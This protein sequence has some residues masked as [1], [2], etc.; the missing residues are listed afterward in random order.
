MSIIHD[1]LKKVEG[2]VTVLDGN[3]SNA[4]GFP[5]AAGLRA[6]RGDTLA[7]TQ[8]EN[9]PRGVSPRSL[10][11]VLLLGVLL[12]SSASWVFL[13]KRSLSNADHYPPVIQEGVWPPLGVIPPLMAVKTPVAAIADNPL[14][15]GI[16][17]YRAGKLDDALSQLKL[18][19]VAAP[20][21]P[22]IHNNIGAVYAAK[23]EY[24]IAEQFFIKA[25]EL[26]PNYA[27]AFNNRGAVVIKQGGDTP[28]GRGGEAI[29]YFK[30]ALAINPGYVDAHLNA[31]SAYEKNGDAES[32]L[33]HYRSYLE[34]STDNEIKAKMA[35][36]ITA[37]MGAILLGQR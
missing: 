19:L 35:E 13:Q 20:D 28:L 8:G 1:A 21:N 12:V 16:E 36:K 5:P 4:G 11:F 14:K 3:F 32:A 18:A 17:L 24:T 23:N 33:T 34:L 31:A 9:G 22:V 30:K 29:G 37:L 7:Q 10:T 15:N 2:G 25:S 6:P 27:E 26:N